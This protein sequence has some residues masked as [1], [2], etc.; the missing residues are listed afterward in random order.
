MQIIE[1]VIPTTS[2]KDVFE[3]FPIGD[4]HIGASNC[5]EEHF[6]DYVAYIKS[7]PNAYWVGGG[8]YCDYI[9]PHDNRFSIR[10]VPDW[11]FVGSAV[12]I[13]EKLL[14]IS[15]QQRERFVSIVEPIAD[16]CLGLIEGNHETRIMDATYNGHHYVM[17]DELG[18]PNLTDCAFIRLRFCAGRG[19]GASVVVFIMHGF[20]GGRTE[21]AEPNHLKRISAYGEADIFLRGHSHTFE[22]RPPE[23]RLYIPRK[24][25]LPD[26]LCER[27]VRKGN[28]GCWIR[29][30]AVG[31]PT[32]DSRAAYP[33]RPLVAMEIRIKPAN[34]RPQRKGGKPVTITAP[35]I[36]MVECDYRNEF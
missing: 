31:A 27:S 36:K 25:A 28:W 2:K 7:K 6:R 13:K 16:K 23:P 18:V 15:R 17:C 1:K 19:S 5:A 33:P 32:Y 12:N 26:E 21:G 8:D 29:S 4:V 34:N 9:T 20:G 10:N 24:G 22:I 30:Y 11:L 3:L 14:D 35:Q